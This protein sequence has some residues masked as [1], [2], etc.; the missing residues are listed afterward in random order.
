MTRRR[1][2]PDAQPETWVEG[3][4]AHPEPTM[5]RARRWAERGVRVRRGRRDSHVN[6]TLIAGGLGQLL[7]AGILLNLSIGS[8]L[9]LEASGDARFVRHPDQ[10][11]DRSGRGS[12][13][14]LAARIRAGDD[15]AVLDPPSPSGEPPRTTERR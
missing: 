6:G 5:A 13:E 3:P 8:E 7:L 2:D 15:P 14:V 1:A 9:I 12:R 11:A 4:T 10:A